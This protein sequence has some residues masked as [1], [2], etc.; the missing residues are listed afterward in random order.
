[1]TN[2]AKKK[3]LVEL[4][5]RSEGSIRG[6]FTRF[7]ISAP[8]TPNTVAAAIKKHGK[9]F[10]DH[11]YKSYREAQAKDPKAFAYLKRDME[12]FT[13]GD[14]VQG[15]LDSESLIGGG[16]TQSTSDQTPSDSASTEPVTQSKFAQVLDGVANVFSEINTA[17]GKKPPVLN[18]EDE[19]DGVTPSGDDGKKGFDFSFKNPIVKI[20]A[21]II[22][23][24]V[25]YW[26]VKK[27]F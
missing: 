4:I 21:A 15:L 17:A 2:E 6:A 1:M 27:L 26:V 11:L 8:V 7:R 3:F 13:S 24:G 19:K 14:S 25:V 20:G 23:L 12:Y 18:A 22:V 5:R 9:E 16:A 10:K